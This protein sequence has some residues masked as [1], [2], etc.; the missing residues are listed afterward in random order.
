[1]GAQY[2]RFTPRRDRQ[3]YKCEGPEGDDSVGIPAQTR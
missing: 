2:A 1:M 3:G